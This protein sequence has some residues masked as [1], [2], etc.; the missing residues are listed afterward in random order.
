METQEPI[1]D[2]GSG[3]RGTVAGGGALRYRI[4]PARLHPL[5]TTAALLVGGAVAGFGARLLGGG[6]WYAVL[7]LGVVGALAALLFPTEVV[8]D[9]AQL[10]VRQLGTPRSYVLSDF[11]R[12]EV[13]SDVV[14][15]A[16]LSREGEGDPLEAAR[17]LPLP[18]P[19]EPAARARLLALL[20]AGLGRR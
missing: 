18:L 15:R 16:E 6:G 7:G 5:R 17:T 20:E 4:W 14:A 19:E 10:V 13:V 2:A 12:L 3:A 9:G 8:V 1:G 11:A